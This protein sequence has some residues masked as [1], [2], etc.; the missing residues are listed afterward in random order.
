MAK[1]YATKEQ[2]QNKLKEL[3]EQLEILVASQPHTAKKAGYGQF[4]KDLAETLAFVD[5]INSKLNLTEKQ[6]KRFEVGVDHLIKFIN[7]EN[8]AYY[9]ARLKL[10]KI[11]KETL[12]KVSGFITSDPADQNASNAYHYLLNQQTKIDD[13]PLTGPFD[14]Q[15]LYDKNQQLHTPIK[16]FCK[17]LLLKKQANDTLKYRKDYDSDI[18]TINDYKFPKISLPL[19]QS[20]KVVIDTE[21]PR[22]P[23]QK[24]TDRAKVSTNGGARATASAMGAQ[25]RSRSAGVNASSSASALANS[26]QRSAPT[27]ITQSDPQQ[28]STSSESNRYYF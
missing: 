2:K 14:N 20:A 3:H 1:V 6:L 18:A 19:Y 26:H 7:E 22:R 10:S 12:T 28:R 27:R 11:N 8:E 21:F 4:N 16:S 24:K 25:L 15:Q 23:V 9:L 13:S 17:Q 5:T